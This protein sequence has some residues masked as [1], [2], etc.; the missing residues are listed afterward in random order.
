MKATLSQTPD[1]RREI[2][3]KRTPPILAHH[4]GAFDAHPIE[5]GIKVPRVIGEAIFDLRLP[6]L[7]EAD[8]VGGNAVSNWRHGRNDVP[9]D[10]GRCR[11]A[12]EEKR[13]R[14]SPS[15]R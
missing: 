4:I 3:G 10:V 11:I 2:E 1:A 9:P 13:N 6:G 12:V 15:L 5:E 8:K 14:R 7:A